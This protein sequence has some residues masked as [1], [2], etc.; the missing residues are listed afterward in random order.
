MSGDSATLSQPSQLT[1]SNPLFIGSAENPSSILVSNVFDGIGFTSWKRS[2]TISLVAKNK[3]GFVDGSVTQPLTTDATYSDWYR[4]NS[5]VISWILNSLSKN[6]AESV[7]F[8][9]TADQIWKELTQRYEKSDGALIYQIQQLYSLN[10]GSD[11]FS[12]Y[13]TKLTKVW[14]E[15]RMV[16]AIP[17]DEAST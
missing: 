4:A 10:Q 3:F 1:S 8:F 13:F 9:Q 16:Q 15:L 17:D 6:I 2:M 11:N 12:T 14:D 5:M 7:L